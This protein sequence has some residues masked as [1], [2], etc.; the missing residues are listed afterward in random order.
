MPLPDPIIFGATPDA[1]KLAIL[2]AFK[3]R[4]AVTRRHRSHI[5][6]PMASFDNLVSCC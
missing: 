6:M 5:S 4:T 3:R 1:D 2:A